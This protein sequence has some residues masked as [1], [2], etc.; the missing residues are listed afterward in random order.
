MCEV[1]LNAEPW[2]R[3]GNTRPEVV[4]SASEGAY[5]VVPTE[6][7]Y[8]AIGQT[9]RVVSSPYKS[10]IGK[11]TNLPQNLSHLPSGL[12]AKTAEVLLVNGETIQVPLANIEIIG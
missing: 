2:D 3:I 9:V 7:S 8:F 12:L 6:L 4:I 11:L 1:A 10:M 5:P